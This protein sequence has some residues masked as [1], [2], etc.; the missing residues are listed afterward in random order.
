MLYLLLDSS[1]SSLA[2]AAQVASWLLVGPRAAARVV[3]F[4]F[5]YTLY[6]TLCVPCRVWS[7]GGSLRN[8]KTS[9]FLRAATVASSG[10]LARRG[11]KRG[12]DFEFV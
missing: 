12:H 11:P 3:F 9:S 6:A 10:L 1:D 4:P 5:L 8:R 2:V 7:C